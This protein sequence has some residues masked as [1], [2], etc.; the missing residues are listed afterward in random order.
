M[1]KFYLRNAALYEKLV[2]GF[3]GNAP[4]VHFSRHET[5]PAEEEVQEQET[6]TELCNPAMIVSAR[7]RPMLS[8]DLA[9]KFPCAVYPRK[10]KTTGRSTIV[11]L[12]DLY[13]YPY[14]RPI[15]KVRWDF[16]LS[17]S[18]GEKLTAAL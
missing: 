2:A 7:I 8:N 18:P 10:S 1:D 17:I 4:A 3:D 12:H 6:I 9:E 11:D 14:G 15:L 16:P 5:T 13:N